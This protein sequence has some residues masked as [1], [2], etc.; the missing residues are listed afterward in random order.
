MRVRP[1][2]R[3]LWGSRNV[4][5]PP[6]ASSDNA[7]MSSQSLRRSPYVPLHKLYRICADQAPTG[8]CATPE[9]DTT[10]ADAPFAFMADA[11]RTLAH[12]GGSCSGVASWPVAYGA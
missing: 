6:C 8:V 5:E 9:A 2:S 1:D 10:R 3:P 4:G 7:H 11:P 12:T